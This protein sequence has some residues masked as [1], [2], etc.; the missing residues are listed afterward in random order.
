MDI[1]SVAG[2][3]IVLIGVFLGMVLKG[4]DPVA[5]FTNAPAILIVILGS[6]GAVVLSYPMDTTKN[7][8]KALMKVFFPGP[9]PDMSGTITQ[10]TS[11]ASGPA[12]RACWP[13]RRRP[14]RSRTRS[15]RGRC[16]R[17]STAPTPTT[18]AARCSPTSR[19][20]RSATSG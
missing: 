17:S 11:L 6:I 9:P 4:A 19:P 15:C 12:V 18:C 20:P 14:A 16:A 8:L 3:V 1:A 2:L 5:M 13:S 7:A 10:I